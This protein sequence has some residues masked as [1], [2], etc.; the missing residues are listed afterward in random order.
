MQLYETLER[1][2]EFIDTFYEST[3]KLNVVGGPLR[4]IEDSIQSY[5]SENIDKRVYDIIFNKSYIHYP[6]REKSRLYMQLFFAKD[7]DRYKNNIQEGFLEFPNRFMK[8]ILTQLQNSTNTD[9]ND[10]I[11]EQMV[12]Y[13]THPDSLW[14]YILNK[15]S[16]ED[17]GKD[18]SIVGL[19]ER[20]GRLKKKGFESKKKAPELIAY[21]NRLIVEKNLTRQQISYYKKKFYEEQVPFA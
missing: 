5:G 19:E 3:S 9:I 8:G 11:L 17:D 14:E 10:K 1:W 12:D 6:E 18:K 7:C 16:I 15:S 20:I 4:F 21:K 2:E 13:P